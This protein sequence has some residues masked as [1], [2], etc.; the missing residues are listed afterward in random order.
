MTPK[1]V[2]M[3]ILILLL[4]GFGG[5]FAWTN[6]ATRVNVLFKLTPSL[7]WD[8]GPEGITLPALL[9]I[10]FLAG[11]V[12]AGIV[13]S[14]SL[15]DGSRRIK[16]LTRQVT[17][18]QDEIEFNK[19]NAAP[20]TAPSFGSPTRSAPPAP[21]PAAPATDDDFDDFDADDDDEDEEEDSNASTD[22]D[23]LI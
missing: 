8:L 20:A 23:D 15:F 14:L 19:R 17:A 12:L 6:H 13:G 22:L 2:S 11:A 3:L 5:L 16:M 1:R 9:A 18:L 7:A 4:G 10:A 21:A